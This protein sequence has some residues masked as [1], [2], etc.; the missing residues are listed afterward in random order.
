MLHPIRRT[1]VNTA[2]AFGVVGMFAGA[3]GA[4]VVGGGIQAR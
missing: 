1:V 3:S 4:Q 2:L